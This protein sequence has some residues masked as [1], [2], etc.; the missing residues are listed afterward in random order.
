MYLCVKSAAAAVAAS[1]Y[2]CCY[3]SSSC[4]SALCAEWQNLLLIHWIWFYSVISLSTFKHDIIHCMYPVA[5]LPHLS[6]PF[7][8]K[9]ISG[10][11]GAKAGVSPPRWS[12][13]DINLQI[14]LLRSHPLR[15]T[16]S[17]YSP[18]RQP[19]SAHNYRRESNLLGKRTF[20]MFFFFV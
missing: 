9:V 19:F 20:P 14:Y 12:S 7:G 16:C 1:L 4:C 13:P 6:T 18:T 10:T 15:R 5:V 2:W 3:C 17:A 11:H 8:Y